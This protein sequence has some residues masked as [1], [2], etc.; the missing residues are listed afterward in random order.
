VTQQYGVSL[1]AAS[2]YKSIALISINQHQREKKNENIVAA[3]TAKKIVAMA[4][5]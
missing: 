5:A 1:K 3:K 2:A 4:S